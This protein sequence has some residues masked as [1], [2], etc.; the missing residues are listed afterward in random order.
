MT[1]PKPFKASAGISVAT[2]KIIRE[3]EKDVGKLDQLTP[4]TKTAKAGQKGLRLE[5]SSFLKSILLKTQST[6]LMD[7]LYVMARPIKR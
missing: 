1:T 4:K 2:Q 5:G 3:I 6:F 7:A